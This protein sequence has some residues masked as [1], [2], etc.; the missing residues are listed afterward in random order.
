MVEI[1]CNG[2]V[3]YRRPSMEHP[4]VQEALALIA[5]HKSLPAGVSSYEVRE[6]PPPPS[7]MQKEDK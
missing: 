3:H 1:I 7:D 5:W 4:D 2:K 6:V